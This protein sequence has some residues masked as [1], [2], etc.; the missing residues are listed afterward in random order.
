MG[1]SGFLRGFALNYAMLLVFQLFLGVGLAAVMPSL[2]KLVAAWFTHERTGFAVGMSISGFSLGGALGLSVTPYLLMTSNTWRDVFFVY[3]TWTLILAVV[4][5]CLAQEP[6]ETM[7][8]E[9][10]VGPDASLTRDLLALLKAKQVWL[11]AGLYLSASACYDTILIWLP[12]ILTAKDLQ[13]TTAGLITSMLPFGF[14]A[15]S[16]T[17][18]ILSDRAGLRKPFIIVLG[19]ISGP[20]IFAVGTALGPAAWILAFLVGFTTIGVLTLVL[21]IPIE[22]APTVFTVASAVGL[23]SSIGNIGSFLMPTVV[24]QI[25]DVTGSFTLAIYLL[26]VLGELMVLLGLLLTETGRKRKHV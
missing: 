17:I 12:S 2:P 16:L 4:W 5:W 3:G 26:A 9:R 6:V 13:P 25:R 22:F 7:R 18:G 11:L 15:A 10:K 19:L 23:I 24:G 21:T 14:L 8:L 20:A 1:I